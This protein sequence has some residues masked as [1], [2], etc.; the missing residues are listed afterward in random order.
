[1]G[2]CL[3]AHEA[4]SWSSHMLTMNALPP[5]PHHVGA[6]WRDT[7]LARLEQQP[8]FLE[9]WLSHQRRD[10]FWRQ[11]SI[12]EDFAALDCG[13]LLIGGW[14]DGYT[15]GVD[16]ALRGLSA[17][18][19]PC[20]AIVGPWSHEWPEIAEPGPQI[21]FLQEALRWWDHWLKGRDTGVMDEPP[22][23]TYLQNAIIPAARQPHRPGRWVTEPAW[24]SPRIAALRL[25]PTAEGGLADEPTPVAQRSWLGDPLA[26][27][28]SGVWCPYGRPSD[29][30]PDQRAEDGRS[31]SFT[32]PPLTQPLEVLG[33]PYVELR[34]AAD[35]PW[36]MVAARVCDVSP[37]GH[38]LLVTRG[39]MNLAHRNG[40]ED[41]M[42][43][44]RDETMAVCVPLDFAGHRFDVGHRVRLSL[45]PT[46]WPFAWPSPEAVELTVQLGA[47]TALALPRRDPAAVDSDVAFAAPERAA[48]I[49]HAEPRDS[50][51]FTYDHGLGQSR[52][53]I[54]YE[55][56]T[57]LPETELVFD[58]Y[59]RDD[60]VLA[61]DDPLSARLEHHAQRSMRRGEWEVRVVVDTSMSADATHFTVTSARDAYEGGVRVHALRRSVRVP[62]DGV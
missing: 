42:A 61:L 45:S 20:R 62:R 13:V 38:S 29:L 8:V 33:R 6:G 47:Q 19:V 48:P 25:F 49:G 54:V 53:T 39:L 9:T 11:G 27:S 14:A 5:D 16:R 28:E 3:L 1:M 37:R 12:C 10:D 26:G 7:W 4:L 35:R 31:L 60:Y 57:E 56:R 40:H 24:P 32:T 41:V 34:L 59:Q 43:I 15:N 18:G 21:G 2:G 36:G 55:T 17:A 23:R 58:E 52:T 51:R 22:L 30:A 50:H 46:Y 44:D